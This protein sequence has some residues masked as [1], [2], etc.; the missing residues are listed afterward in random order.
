MWLRPKITSLTVQV[1]QYSA[2]RCWKTDWQVTTDLL[3]T[4]QSI[5]Q[6]IINLFTLSKKYKMKIS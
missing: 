4:N 2:H 1:K 5:N 3:G 6:S